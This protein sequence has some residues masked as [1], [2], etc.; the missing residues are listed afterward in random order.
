MYSKKVNAKELIKIAPVKVWK[1]KK[2]TTMQGSDKPLLFA[3][4]N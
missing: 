2:A 4:P 3:A 1:G